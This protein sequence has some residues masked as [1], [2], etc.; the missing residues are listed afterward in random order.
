VEA[1]ETFGLL[2]AGNA[3]DPGGLG[4]PTIGFGVPSADPSEVGRGEGFVASN[5]SI[6]NGFN[7]QLING[8]SNIFPRQVGA[9]KL[10]PQN[11]TMALKGIGFEYD[12]TYDISAA[13]IAL[14][15]DYNHNGTVDAADYVLWRKGDPSADSNGDT[16]VDQV[17]F[18]FWRTNFGNTAGPGA[19]SGGLTAAGVPEPASVGLVG[20]GLVAFAMRW[21]FSAR[22]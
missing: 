2:S 11:G 15:G 13:P 22:R 1:G 20:L 7:E 18:D 14:P 4:R 8:H 21:R 16:F 6:E 5:V 3:T 19:G 10:I 9:F 12:V 17:D